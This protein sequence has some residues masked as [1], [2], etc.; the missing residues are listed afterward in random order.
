[1]FREYLLPIL[2]WLKEHELA[3]TWADVSGFLIAIVGFAATL[4]N[5]SRSKNAA[6]KAQEA[7]QAARDSIRR[8]DTIVDFSTVITLLEDIKRAHRSERGACG[9]QGAWPCSQGPAA[10]CEQECHM[11]WMPLITY[12]PKRGSDRMASMIS[13]P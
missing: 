3:S 12:W 5:V 10:E 4:W 7:A 8:V 11:L 1:M 13:A 2:A 9:Q 6:I